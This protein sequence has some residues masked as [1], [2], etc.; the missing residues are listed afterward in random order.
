MKYVEGVSFEIHNSLF[1]IGH[2]IQANYYSV[3]I[4]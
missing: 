4:F 3:R 2:S 1:D